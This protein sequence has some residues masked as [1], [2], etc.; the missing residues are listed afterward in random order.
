MFVVIKYMNHLT[1]NSIEILSIVDTLQLADSIALKKVEENY[2]L[3]ISNSIYLVINIKN[4]ISEYSIGN[5]LNRYVYA[6]IKHE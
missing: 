1:L 4:V 2:G 5:G 6:I 3:D